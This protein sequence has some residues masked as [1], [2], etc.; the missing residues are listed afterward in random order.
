MWDD[1]VKHLTSKASH[2]L[3]YLRHSLFASLPSIKATAYRYIVRP[4]L[5]Y[6]SPVWCLYSTSDISRL[7]SIQRHAALWVCGSRWNPTNRT[8]TKSSDFC[9]QELRWPALQARRNY[10]SV[11]ALYMTYCINKCP[12]LLK[13]IF[14]SLPAVLDPII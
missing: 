5:E 3:N 10:F 4:M 14:I 9:L 11:I 1:H 12:Y 2:S 6:A 13:T 7:E 8:W